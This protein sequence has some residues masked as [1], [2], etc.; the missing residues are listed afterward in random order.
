MGVILTGY[1]DDKRQQNAFSAHWHSKFKEAFA[2][3]PSLQ[4]FTWVD[5]N[6]DDFAGKT[7]YF[8]E[9]AGTSGHAFDPLKI[10]LFQDYFYWGYSSPI[11]LDFT[12]SAALLSDYFK[13]LLDSFSPETKS[14]LGK[15]KTTK[16]SSP[17]RDK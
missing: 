11:D 13:K 17:R 1:Q 6:D 10:E 16:R 7:G 5:E 9:V 12:A 8:K 2:S 14:P 4:A 15:G 3:D